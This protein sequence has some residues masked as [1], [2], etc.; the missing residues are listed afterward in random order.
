M[1]VAYLTPCWFELTSLD[2]ALHGPPKF[3]HNP[4]AWSVAV[5]AT[6]LCQL[7]LQY[8]IA[9]WNWT[10][11]GTS[12]GIAPGEL[13]SPEHLKQSSESIRLCQPKTAKLKSPSSSLPIPSSASSRMTGSVKFS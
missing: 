9:K 1:H 10:A 8:A 3:R 12:Q 11:Q 13:V 7:V 5:Y 2:R 4:I 6:Q